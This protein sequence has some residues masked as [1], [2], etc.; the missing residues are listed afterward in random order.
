[1]N[2]TGVQTCAL[3]ISVGVVVSPGV[4]PDAPALAA[5]REA[6]IPILSE[7]DLGFRALAGSGTRIIAVTGTNG[8][9][10]TTALVAHLLRSAGLRAEAAGNIGRPLSDVVLGVERF[11]WLAV[12][13]SSFQLHDSP[14][15]APDVGIVT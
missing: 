11:Q 13:A 9:T 4:P 8:K 2:V 7:L 5:A 10:T 1:R 15:F 14:A 6:G 3:P 12:E